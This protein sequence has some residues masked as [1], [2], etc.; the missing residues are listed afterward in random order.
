MSVFDKGRERERENEREREKEE[1]NAASVITFNYTLS[2][3]L[4]GV[5]EWKSF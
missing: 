2:S 3:L 1:K 4:N 5:S